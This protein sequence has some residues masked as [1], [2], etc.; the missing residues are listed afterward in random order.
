MR[1]L[2]ILFPLLAFALT[3]IIWGSV[4][5]DCQKEVAVPYC[6]AECEFEW[7]VWD[8]SSYCWVPPGVL[9]EGWETFHTGCAGRMHTLWR[10]G[11]TIKIPATVEIR[12]RPIEDTRGATDPCGRDGWP[13]WSFDGKTGRSC[14]YRSDL[15]KDACV[16][17]CT[18]KP[19][20]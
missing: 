15:S 4:N 1:L 14:F 7:L 5:S 16:P 8:P 3:C 17:A 11:M 9:P 18:T 13:L 12:I 6:E 2:S 19:S 10:G 20:S